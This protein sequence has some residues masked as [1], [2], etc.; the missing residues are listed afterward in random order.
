MIRL[1][2]RHLAVVPL[3]LLII[4]TC[5]ALPALAEEN[6][7]AAPASVT[8]TQ[9]SP[10]TD[11]MQA[12]A[13]P[14]EESNPPAK[15]KR[16]LVLMPSF[17]S[18]APSDSK[19]QDRFGSSWQSIGLA[20]AYKTRNMDPRKIEFR[21][22]GI[23][24]KSSLTS[25]Y[26][27]PVGLG[28]N[29]ILS[30]SKS[31]TTYAGATANL[32]IAKVKSIPDAVDTGWQLKGGAGALMG[33]NLGQKLNVQASYYLIPKLGGFDLSGFNVSAHIELWTF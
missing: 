21:L 11:G 30:S 19:T 5:A 1:G 9:D 18:Y 28:L 15:E 4:C 17:N 16:R 13:Q 20:V 26:V 31:L 23:A 24:Q 6:A 22:D 12:P 2:K 27:F 10:S 14:D 25:A 3:V 29:K 32:Y 8:A 33:A 7:N